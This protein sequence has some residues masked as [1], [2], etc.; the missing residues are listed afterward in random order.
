MDRRDE[1]DKADEE[2]MDSDNDESGVNQQEL[3]AAGEGDEGTKAG[4]WTDEEHAKFLEA[5]D[6]YGK[7]WNKVHKHVGTRT[8]AQTR[9]HAQKYFNK[10]TKKTTKD[11]AKIH[12]NNMEVS[13]N[14]SGSSHRK[15]QGKDEMM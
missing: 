12:G 10:L 13:S 15:S 11:E 9:S 1:M 3:L 14:R 8:S 6:L 7:N 2:R 5:L 4:R